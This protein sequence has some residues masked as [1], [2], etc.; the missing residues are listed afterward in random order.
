MQV[1]VF[2][3]C[4]REARRNSEGSSLVEGWT[5]GMEL[6]LPK[7]IAWETQWVLESCAKTS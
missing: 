6:Q 5:P 4:L 1:E 2:S 7:F 3:S